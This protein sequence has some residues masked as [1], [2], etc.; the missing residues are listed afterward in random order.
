MKIM[1]RHNSRKVFFFHFFEL[2]NIFENF[3]QKSQKTWF[4][5]RHLLALFGH[6]FQKYCQISK[7]EGKKKTLAREVS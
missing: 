1:L 3:D 6:N 4:L 2:G 7:F 5:A